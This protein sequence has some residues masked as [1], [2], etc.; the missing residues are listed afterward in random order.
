MVGRIGKYARLQADGVALAI[1]A[2]AFAEEACPDDFSQSKRAM[3]ATQVSAIERISSRERVPKG[4]GITAIG[5]S[6]A[7]SAFCCARPR[8]MKLVEQ[9]VNAAFARFAISTLSWILHDVQDPQSPEPVIT[10][11]Q[12]SAMSFN[13]A[14]STGTWPDLRC[15]MTSATL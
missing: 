13:T 8:P 3:S 9:T 6:G 4:C 7:P 2:A 12:R 15:L 5:R 1:G 14:S 11:S 10:A